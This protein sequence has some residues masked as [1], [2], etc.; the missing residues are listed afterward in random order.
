MNDFTQ[1]E[2]I[3]FKFN[4]SFGTFTTDANHSNAGSDKFYEKYADHAEG[5]VTT[6]VWDFITENNIYD[7]TR[8]GTFCATVV[9]ITTG[10]HDV[11]V[12]CHESQVGTTEM[13]RCSSTDEA[14]TLAGDFITAIEPEE[15]HPTWTF[16]V[17]DAGNQWTVFMFGDGLV[18]ESAEAAARIFSAPEEPTGWFRL[19]EYAG[20]WSDGSDPTITDESTYV[21]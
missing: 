4:Y 1:A 9:W 13:Y 11:I 20:D 14:Q 5:L 3:G 8:E 7:D 12:L 18:T 17:S 6:E 15:I 21:A 19:R 10:N 2:T 16:E